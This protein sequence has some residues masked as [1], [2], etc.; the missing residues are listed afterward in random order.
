MLCWVEVIMQKS[1]SDNC[2]V[3][4]SIRQSLQ[5]SLH[6]P[7]AAPHVHISKFPTTP[8]LPH[9]S[10]ILP[11][12]SVSLSSRA[13]TCCNNSC[14]WIRQS[15]DQGTQV[16]DHVGKRGVVLSRVSSNSH[17]FRAPKRKKRKIHHL[18]IKNILLE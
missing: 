7:R 1:G 14:N 4:G 13:V 15:G 18:Y 17:H 11:H 9:H 5:N 3:I 6:I 8:T 10:L 12:H 16:G 2:R